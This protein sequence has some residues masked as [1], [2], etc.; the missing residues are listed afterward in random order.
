MDATRRDESVSEDSMLGGRVRLLQPRH[1]YRA[2]IDP[3]LLA[4]GAALLPG[5]LVLDLGC[6]VGAAG[7]CLLARKPEC[8]VIG[9]ERQPELVALAER[10]IVANG[11]SRRMAVVT[12]D[13][14]APP[15]PLEFGVFDWVMANPPFLAEGEH[16]PSPDASKAAANGEGDTALAEWIAA[17]H[18][19]L[20]VR[21]T[22]MLV[23]RADR[24]DQVL[25]QL[26]TGGFGDLVL[27]PL[28][29]RAGQAARRILVAGRKDSRGVMRLAPGLVLHQADGRFTPETEAVLRGGAALDIVRASTHAAA[30]SPANAQPQD[31]ASGAAESI[32]AESVSTGTST[33]T[34]VETVAA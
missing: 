33:E 2:A 22:L 28:W 1:G 31:T 3:V 8:R 23:H 14:V 11:Q 12:G 26:R 20:R 7:L 27:F 29:P 5:E 34:P 19:F 30:R 25:S 17:S 24:T 15:E 13:L 16:T 9:L 4:A 6:G 18:R 10:N 21:G 32:P